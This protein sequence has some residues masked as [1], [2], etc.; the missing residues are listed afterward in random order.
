MYHNRN[1]SIPKGINFLKVKVTMT[2]KWSIYASEVS[3]NLCNDSDFISYSKAKR[4]KEAK[5]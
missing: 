5:Y 3:R 2:Q 1:T 4:E